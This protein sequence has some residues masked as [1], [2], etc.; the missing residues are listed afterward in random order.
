MGFFRRNNEDEW[1]IIS[2]EEYAQYEHQ[3]LSPSSNNR[4]E[5]IPKK[6]QP[7]E[8]HPKTV[9]KEISHKNKNNNEINF[10]EKENGY[11]FEKESSSSLK[12]VQKWPFILLAF[13]ITVS[14]L[15]IIGYMNTDFDENGNSY[16][17]PLNI[18]YKRRYALISDKVLDYINDI[19]GDLKRDINKLP[20]DYLSVS[21]K[22]T[23]EIETL[24]TKTDSLS[25][26]TNVPKDLQSYHSSLLNFSLLT[27]EFLQNLISSYNQS[28]YDEF[29]YNGL[30]DFNG[31]LREINSLRSQMDNALF[32]NMDSVSPADTNGEDRSS[33]SSRKAT[34]DDT[35]NSLF[36]KETDTDE[37]EDEDE[38][39][40]TNNDEMQNNAFGKQEG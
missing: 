1:D 8:N 12:K 7:E 24:K 36:P 2:D 22:L 11:E 40:N 5:H 39:T 16:V 4:S 26:Y 6:R 28:D 30:T 9:Q 33:E 25:R 34:D 21:N 35:E 32:S 15:G 14:S 29:A 10:L 13:V 31:Y 17:I 27:Q 38:N 19:S 3:T 37:R 18:H 23:E 20:N